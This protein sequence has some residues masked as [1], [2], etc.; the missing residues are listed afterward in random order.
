MINLEL[1]KIF[2]EVAKEGNITRASEKLNISQP[3][4]TKHIKNLESNLDTQLFIRTQ[5]GVTLTETGKSIFN[6]IKQALILINDSENDI[7]DYNNL[8]KGVIKIG[9]STT[10]TKKFLFKYIETFHKEFSNIKIEINT[11]PTSEAIKLLKI[12]ILDFVI[13]K[14]P[15]SKENELDYIELGAL[16]DIFVANKNYDYLKNK[17]LKLK[18]ISSLEI[19]TQKEPSNS[20]KTFDN[21]CEENN[22]K[23]NSI[24]NISSSNLLIDFVKIGYG[25]GFVTKLYVEEELKRNELFELNIQPKPKL[26][27]FGII[28]LKNNNLSKCSEKFIKNILK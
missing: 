21:F 26:Y 28:K 22:T 16:E 8:D 15:T 17:T 11:D 12:G 19:L 14:F 10:L 6:N 4:V 5:K 24:M 2:Y 20:R 3:A 27:K 13:S 25:I 1:Y 23:I 7:K 18:D 9:I